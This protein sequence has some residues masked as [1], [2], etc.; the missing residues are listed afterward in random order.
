[1]TRCTLLQHFKKS[2]CIISQGHPFSKKNTVKFDRRVFSIRVSVLAQWLRLKC[3]CLSPNIVTTVKSGNWTVY[4]KGGAMLYSKACKVNDFESKKKC[5][6]GRHT[7]ESPWSV[8][9]LCKTL[10][11]FKAS[12]LTL[13]KNMKFFLYVWLKLSNS[14]QC[15]IKSRKFLT[16]KGQYPHTTVSSYVISQMYASWSLFSNAHRN[17]DMLQLGYFPHIQFSP[18]QQQRGFKSC[19]VDKRNAMNPGLFPALYVWLYWMVSKMV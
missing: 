3:G 17:Q 10:T 11:S 14:C 18:Q 15:L 8:C 1:M 2:V 7:S 12:L 13:Y 19:S 5:K 4:C 16:G 6:Q 9:T